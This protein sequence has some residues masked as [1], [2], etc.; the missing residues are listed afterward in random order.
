MRCLLD[1]DDCGAS[2]SLS[3]LSSLPART[4]WS[5]VLDVNVTVACLPTAPSSAGALGD[6]ASGRRGVDATLFS[7][8]LRAESMRGER[9]VR[10]DTIVLSWWRRGAIDST[11]TP[12][13]ALPLP[14]TLRAVGV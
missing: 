12:L 11:L 1:S 2:P 13:L 10:A 3:L 5:R 8:D 9:G 7:G 14:A 4:L 6:T